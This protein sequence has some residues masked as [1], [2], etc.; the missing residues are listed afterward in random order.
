ML[1]GVALLHRNLVWLR[2]LWLMNSEGWG[3]GD[4]PLSQPLMPSGMC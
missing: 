4:R 1:V 3:G 2:F